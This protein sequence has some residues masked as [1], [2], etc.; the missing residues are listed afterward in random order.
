MGEC[1]EVVVCTAIEGKI[2]RLK[3]LLEQRSK[4]KETHA[5]CIRAWVGRSIDGS[6]VLLSYAEFV[7][8]SSWEKISKIVTEQSDKR[9]GGIGPILSAPPLVGVFQN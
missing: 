5:G 2:E 1:I 8:E 9:D 4:R 6:N 3:R 7:D